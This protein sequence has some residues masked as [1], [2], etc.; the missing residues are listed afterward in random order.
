MSVAAGRH[1]ERLQGRVVVTHQLQDVLLVQLPGLRH[2]QQLVP[3]VLCLEE[4]ERPKHCRLRHS[5]WL[6]RGQTCVVPVLERSEDGCDVLPLEKHLLVV[7]ETGERE[8]EEEC[9]STVE[10]LRQEKSLRGK[11]AYH[12]LERHDRC[13]ERE[14]P[15]SREQFHHYSVLALRQPHLQS[16]S[17]V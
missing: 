1:L 13:K 11:Q 12:L 7:L 8:L 15:V 10:E 17:I 6:V 5:A 4:R 2:R 9:P 3:G 14:Y 16:A